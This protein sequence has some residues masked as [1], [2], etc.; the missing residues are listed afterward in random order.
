[1]SAENL[2][3][4][5]KR[6][7]ELVDELN[8]HR[9]AY[10][11][12]NTVLISDADYD[13]LLAELESL[14]H[15]F[16]QLVTG[17]SPTQTVGGTANQT[18]A[19][20]EHLDRMMSLD[21]VFSKEEFALWSEKFADE[22]FLCE[23]KIDGLAINLRYLNGLLVSAATRGDGVV[24][25]DVT[26]NVLTIKSIPKKLL[27]TSHPKQVEVRGEIFFGIKDFEKL[28][29]GLVAEGKA[30]FANPRNSASGSLRQKDSKV[31]AS[32]PL[33]MLVHGIGAW[34]EAPVQNQS[35]LYELLESW[36]LPTSK[37]FRV[38]KNASDA[39]K[40]VDEF[41]K[42]RHKLEHEI[43]GVVIKVD[44]LA[45][46]HQ[47][48]FT[49]RAPRWAI[50]YKYAPEQVNTKLLDIRVSV[51]RTGRAT[52]YAVV[53]PVKVAGSVIEFATLHNQEVVIAKGVLIGDTVVIRKAGD[54]IPEILG[55]VVELRDGSE[56]AFVMPS[57][58]P[59]CGSP[60][61]PSS[62]GDVDLRCQ[63]SRSCPAQL[64][65]R[66]AF[67]GSRGVLDIEAL[68]YVAA[69][70]LTQPIDLSSAPLKSE[71]DLFDLKLEDIL[72]VQTKVL[73]ADT[74]IAKLDENGNEKVVHFF[75]KKDGSPAEVAIKL[76]KNLEEA[77]TKPL[78]RILVALSIRHVGPVAAR[79]LTGYF[80]SL[81]RIFSASEIELSQV[82][83]VGATLAQSIKNW[84]EVDWHREI[85]ERWRAAGV[86]LEDINHPGPGVS[87][88]SGGVFEGMSIVA[89]GSLKMF[90]R[91]E[92]EEV[93]ISNGGKAASSVSKKTSF[94]VAG[95]NAGSKL[96]KAEELGI[97]VIDEAEFSRRL[98]S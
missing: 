30:P 65:E 46:Q 22:K 15:E 25:E 7:A 41:E 67:L 60:L 11:E 4:A 14:E 28:N 70:A 5:T 12:G 32:R 88:T 83:G 2:I 1:M 62:E 98:N 34:A 50:A 26:A 69:C 94:V 3:A 93:I 38:V 27:G 92:I 86:Q 81:D 48:G 10:Y 49:S 61:E 79:S 13:K 84:I 55:P 89:T 63:N 21:N 78:W 82:D 56:K 17:D 47:S 54:V 85:I 96:A 53:E 97:E 74:G 95:E 24:G 36:G 59:D 23:L 31:T 20:V 76:L 45:A 75:R 91:E 77:K 51:G 19:P 57:T 72:S 90:T 52:P 33:Q 73:D 64:R 9:R 39:I 87:T 29:A 42:N 35:D 58:C 37:N 80:G 44:S 6:V 8:L 18:F 71:A 43:D 16:P 40:Y 68:G 66:V